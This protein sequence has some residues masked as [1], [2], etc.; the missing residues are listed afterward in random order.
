MGSSRA[1][2][3]A[4]PGLEVVAPAPKSEPRAA[5]IPTNT[6][7]AAAEIPQPTFQNVQLRVIV[8]AWAPPRS[9]YFS[10]FEVFIA[11]KWLNKETPQLIKLVYEFLPYQRRLSEFSADSWKVRKLRVVRDPKCDESLMQIEWPEGPNGRPGLAQSNNAQLPAPADR[12]APLP[13]YRT[14][15]DDYRRAVSSR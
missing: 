3:L 14:T 2:S 9:S 1:A 5:D 11:Q 4:Q 10:S 15:A 12:D 7:P 13:C 6:A 8:S